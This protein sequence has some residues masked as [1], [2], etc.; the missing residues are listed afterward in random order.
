MTSI[1]IGSST[2]PEARE[3][4][5]SFGPLIQVQIGLTEPPSDAEV[6]YA[7]VDTGASDSCIDNTLA[8]RLGLTP[9]DEETRLGVHGAGPVTIYHGWLRVTA[10]GMNKHGRFGGADLAFAPFK[11]LLG[12]DFLKYCIMEYNGHTG[13]VTLTATP[14]PRPQHLPPPP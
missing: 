12:R 8:E 7:L 2:D 4:L 11:A 1:Q 13:L 5:T 9:V 10:L 6:H 3:R 14:P